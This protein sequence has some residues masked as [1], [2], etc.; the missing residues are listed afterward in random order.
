MKSPATAT[1]TADISLVAGLFTFVVPAF[2]YTS[3][4]CVD[5]PGYET[6]CAWSG[7]PASTVY[8]QAYD[9]LSGY[10]D[11][12]DTFGE[13]TSS[14]VD[15]SFSGLIIG[16]SDGSSCA[17]YPAVG[18]HA[19][20]AYSDPAHTELLCGWAFTCDDPAYTEA[21][22]GDCSVA[23]PDPVDSSTSVAA[24]IDAYR[25]SQEM[26]FAWASLGACFLLFLVVVFR[27]RNAP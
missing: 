11:K 4:D 9:W 19:V 20:G 7:A 27:R 24:A 10:E 17:D 15:G 6:D 13:T 1:P 14:D 3:F 8:Y 25:S 16:P 12:G 22:F 5:Q 26:M 18:G 2:A 21:M 23:P